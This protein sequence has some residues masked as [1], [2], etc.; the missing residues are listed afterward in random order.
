MNDQTPSFLRTLFRVAALVVMFLAIHQLL[1]WLNVQAAD[2]DNNWSAPM[3]LGII[4]L[5]LLAYAVLIATPFVPGIEIGFGL[6]AMQGPSIAPLLYIFTVLGLSTS[7]L[8]GRFVHASYVEQ[9]LRDIGLKRAAQFIAE[10]DQLSTQERLDLLRNR[11]PKFLAPVLADGRYLMLAVLIN[12][13]GNAI[14]GGGGGICL[15]C[16]LSR[17][18]TPGLTLLV[19]AIAVLP[20]PLGVYFMWPGFE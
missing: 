15:G 1:N 7:Y 17:I 10:M 11:L 5:I 6:A 2:P 18:F 12:I 13:P 16:G 14:I 9:V 19:I 3:H 4:L 20:F 8:V